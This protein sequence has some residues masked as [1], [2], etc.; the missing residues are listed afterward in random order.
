MTKEFRLRE[1]MLYCPLD[2]SQV[3]NFFSL[4]D[5]RN[6]YFTSNDPEKIIEFYN[7]FEN[8]DQLI[9][10]MKERPKGS[11][12]IHE[13][14]GEK[15]IIVVIPTADYNGKFA[16]ECRENIFK[17]L[18]I[19]F[20]EN[21]GKGDF[22]FNY[23]HNCNI[24]IKKAMD[25]SPKWIA[26]SNDDV[27]KIDSVSTLAEQLSSIDPDYKYL[28]RANKN[29]YDNYVS[30]RMYEF[31]T[32]GLPLI[33]KSYFHSWFD[34]AVLMRL[35]YE[36][37][38][39]N[40]SFHEIRRRSVKRILL[41]KFFNKRLFL[42]ININSFGI[43]SGKYAYLKQGNVF[44]ET[45]ISGFEDIFLSLNLAREGKVELID[46]KIKALEGMTLGGPTDPKKHLTRG[47]RDVV[48][49]I[50]IDELENNYFA[51]R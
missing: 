22:Y 39:F 36:F 34:Q 12:R 19:I 3:D 35:P 50:L 1:N 44:Y 7:G 16:R 10:W 48:N 2:K 18:H 13:V 17:G 37:R 9:Q 5:Y 38:T 20:V 8:R 49:Y 29:L 27:I 28:V 45:F 14:E 15:D 24:G 30:K 31:R 46:Y 43:I 51:N 41:W 4:V 11:H 32:A 21:G 47:M 26:I 42:F 6:N 23:A 40:T 33:L 25:Y